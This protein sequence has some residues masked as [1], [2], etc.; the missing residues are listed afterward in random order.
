MATIPSPLNPLRGIAL[1]CI[2]VLGCDADAPQPS[3]EPSEERGPLGKGDAAGSCL[4]QDGDACG[5]QSDGA[6]WCD[7]QCVAFGDCCA[8]VDE[9]C[10]CTPLECGPDECG[11]V[12]D[13]CGGVVQCGDAGCGDEEECTPS[14]VLVT[15]NGEQNTQPEVA[16]SADVMGVWWVTDEDQNGQRGVFS[17]YYG[18]DDLAPRTEPTR[19][20]SSASSNRTTHVV[21]AFPLADGFAVSYPSFADCELN[22]YDLDGGYHGGARGFGQWCR[23][24]E[25]AGDA[26]GFAQVAWIGNQVL[27]RRLTPAAAL[28]AGAAQTTVSNN[29]TQSYSASIAH[30]ADDDRY[31]IAYLGQKS[32]AWAIQTAFVTETGL[33]AAFDVRLDL[34]PTGTPKVV[35][36]D[37]GYAIAW[38]GRATTNAPTGVWLAMLD[39]DAQPLTEPRRLGDGY[40]FVL[41]HGDGMTAVAFEDEGVLSLELSDAEGAALGPVLD[42]VPGPASGKLP[43]LAWT[44]S[45]FAIAYATDAAGAGLSDVQ[46]DVVC[47]P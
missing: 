23:D 40:D 15:T 34:K 5:G 31:L 38:R 22:R 27:V 9:V 20:I 42:V 7:E 4:T 47:P 2:A 8:D 29:A 6:C 17:R 35:R 37:G 39:D 28:V 30:D 3:E 44:G 21:E 45:A 25:I 41:A 46:L 14:S 36:T 19:L 1:S 13:G 26:D 10:G 33:R 16:V 24:A 12:A 32:N 11:A 43:S 18:R